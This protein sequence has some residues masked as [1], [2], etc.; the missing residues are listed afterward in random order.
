MS[1]LIGAYGSQLRGD[2][3]QP[4]VKPGET[5]F[6]A[7]GAFLQPGDGVASLDPADSSRYRPGTFVL[8]TQIELMPGYFDQGLQFYDNSPNDTALAMPRDTFVNQT[9]QRVPVGYVFEQLVTADPRTGGQAQLAAQA[10][11]GAQRPPYTTNP[12]GLTYGGSIS[13]ANCPGYI[14]VAG[15]C[16][17]PPSAQAYVQNSAIGNTWQ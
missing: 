13:P 6:V 8:P 2:Y 5:Q 11:P 9:P 3:V 16:Q 15:S 12:Y 17:I 14:T 7:K 4:P 10:M 1:Q